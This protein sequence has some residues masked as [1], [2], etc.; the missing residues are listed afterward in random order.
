MINRVMPDEP[1]HQW[2]AHGLLPKGS[3]SHFGAVRT[4]GFLYIDRWCYSPKDRLAS[5]RSAIM[6]HSNTRS[7]TVEH[8]HMKV[9][10]CQ[11]ARILESEECSLEL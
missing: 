7:V 8:D 9:P 4:R 11:E 10:K 6:T 5:L 3:K 2:A 1:G